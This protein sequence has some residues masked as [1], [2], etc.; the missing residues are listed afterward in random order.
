MSKSTVCLDASHQYWD[1][2]WL[3]FCGACW[4]ESCG[5]VTV[6]IRR[7]NGMVR[8]EG[9]GW[10]DSYSDDTYRIEN[11]VGFAF[12]EQEYDSHAA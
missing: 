11:A 6:D 2:G 1:R 8:W 12:D 10:D 4:D 3:L 9:I 5:G 7:E